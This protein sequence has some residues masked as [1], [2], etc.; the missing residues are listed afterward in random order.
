MRSAAVRDGGGCEA[1]SVRHLWCKIIVENG[2]AKQVE[3][4]KLRVDD[5]CV[6][7]L[8]H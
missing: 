3:V 5:I 1:A 8:D 4:A 2:V 6:F 7:S